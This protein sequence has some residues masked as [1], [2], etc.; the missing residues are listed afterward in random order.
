MRIEWSHV[1]KCYEI[2]DTRTRPAR[3]QMKNIGLLDFSAS[4]SEGITVVLG[5]RGAGKST[6]LRVTATV[7]VPDDGNVLYQLTDKET[8]EWSRGRLM[9]SG[10]SSVSPLKQ[11]ISYIPHAKQLDNDMT[12]EQSLI[13]QARSKRVLRS[14]KRAMELLTRWGLAG[15]RHTPL[16]QLRGG[17]LKRFLLAHGLIGKPRIWILDEPTEGLDP[18]GRAL[19]WQELRHPSKGRITLIATERDM[20]LAELADQLILM[21]CGQCRR[22]GKRKWLTAGVKEGTVSAWYRTMQTFSYQQER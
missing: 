12:V 16:Y 7:M 5:P 4:V 1:R 20:A 18:L 3:N 21:E 17:A 11:I 22:H 6:L 10:I 9:A 14:R 8:V 13:M 2:S 19:L 15:V